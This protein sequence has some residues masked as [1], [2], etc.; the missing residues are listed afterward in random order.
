MSDLD[1]R[2]S[3]AMGDLVATPL[4]EPESVPQLQKRARRHR[5]RR[6]LAG[7]TACAI[8]I[9]TVAGVLVVR[10]HNHAKNDVQLLAPNVLLGDI[11]AVV[12]SSKF[13][14][15]G[16]RQRIPASVRAELAQIPGVQEASGIVQRFVAVD[17]GP[18]VPRPGNLP[19]TPILFTY[20]EPSEIN[21]LEGAL[22]TTADQIVIDRDFAT[23][24]DVGIGDDV[25]L[26]L[27]G[28][29]ATVNGSSPRLVKRS[30][31]GIFDVPGLDTGGIPLAAIPAT[32]PLED[33]TFDR[34]DLAVADGAD[35]ETVRA[36]VAQVL[37][38]GYV[39]LTPTELGLADQRSAELDIQH[40]YWA[41]LGTDSD[42]RF[43]AREPDGTTQ[44]QSDDAYAKY[45]ATAD[46]AELRIQRVNFLAPDRASLVYRIYFGGAPSPIITAPQNGEAVL[47]DGKWRIA[48]STACQ[49]ATYVGQ[50]CASFADEPI[51]P[52][53]GWDPPDT[54]ADAAAAFG[55]MADPDATVDARLAAVASSADET[56]AEHRATVAAGVAHDRAYSGQVHFF[57]LG[58]RDH[59]DGHAEVL[60][61]LATDGGGPT[62]PY[63]LIG[64]SFH[65]DHGWVASAE[66][67]CGL[68]GLATQG[69]AP[70]DVTG[71]VTSVPATGP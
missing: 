13:D 51:R 71:A 18:E 49:L 19:R 60:Y 68:T 38:D 30:V 66:Y 46:Q 20:H 53:D 35:L 59:H 26:S 29:F 42:E 3:R 65:L 56:D 11:D 36:A 10:D 17:E 12:L 23:R 69:C 2:L 61:S 55:T 24:Y 31:S 5:V 43:A 7:G 63:P 27:D 9:A 28:T 14:E 47:V 21:V 50:R 33:G 58:V 15:N 52:P 62:S 37:G 64:N 54:L 41:L 45:R 1:D 8:V 34:I 70:P 48:A 39:T 44:Q 6:A 57:V 25:T 67:A 32:Q 22:P 4:A 16:A 40:A